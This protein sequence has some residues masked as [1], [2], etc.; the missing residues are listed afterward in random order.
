AG[1]P[2]SYTASWAGLDTNAQF[3]G[4]VIYAVGEGDA[5]FFDINTLHP[6]VK[7][8]PTVTGTPKVGSTLTGHDAVWDSSGLTVTSQWLS[9]GEPLGGETTHTHV[10]TN[11]DL[12]HKLSFQQ[13]AASGAGQSTTTESLPTAIV[14]ATSTTA[15]TFVDATITTSQHAVLNIVVTSD[16]TATPSGTVTVKYGTKSSA[17]VTLDDSGEGT[18]TLPRLGAATYTI[19]ATYNG[20]GVTGTS[21]VSHK[22]KVS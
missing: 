2:T 14:K 20:D 17:V 19:S 5:T 1:V 21:T 7:T 16:G 3:V 8:K 11:E 15:F 4:F 22:L 13:T 9:D 6:V 12:G 10:L 18:L